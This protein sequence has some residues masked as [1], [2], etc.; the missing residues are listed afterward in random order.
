MKPFGI[1]AAGKR[2]KDRP[3]RRPFRR[4]VGILLVFAL[5][6]CLCPSVPWAAEGQ[7][8]IGLDAA[9]PT[10]KNICWFLLDFDAIFCAP[11]LAPLFDLCRA[12]PAIV[13][14]R[15]VRGVLVYSSP[16]DKERAERRAKIVRKKWQGFMKAND[17]RFPVAFDDAHVFN[18]LSKSGAL[19]L[20]FDFD[21]HVI[22]KYGF[23]LTREQ[24]NE[25]LEL[26]LSGDR[27][28]MEFFHQMMG[29]V[30]HFRP[31]QPGKTHVLFAVDESI[32]RQ[33]VFYEFLVH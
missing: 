16:P 11:C 21:L 17:I 28:D 3:M 14:E 26:L 32:S 18:Y 30:R 24:L 25:I 22:K 20:L 5:A 27:P 10:G 13:Q 7:Q 23:P 12:L 31:A 1:C 19:L 4:L 33:F 8:S 29:L 2:S 15:Q 9:H 6:A